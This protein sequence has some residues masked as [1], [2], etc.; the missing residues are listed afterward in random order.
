MDDVGFVLLLVAAEQFSAI[1]ITLFGYV[2]T[3]TS[4]KVICRSDDVCNVSIRCSLKMASLVYFT[5]KIYLFFSKV[6]N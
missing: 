2:F 4:A 6:L 1:V 3:F 5:F